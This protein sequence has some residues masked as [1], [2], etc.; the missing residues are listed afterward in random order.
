MNSHS[1]SKAAV[2]VLLAISLLAMGCSAQW[3]SVALADLPVLVQMALNIGTVVTTLQSGQ[4]LSAADAAAIQNISNEASKDLNLLQ[5]LYNDYKTNANAATIQ[6]IQSVIADINTNL[7][8]LLQAAHISDAS[9]SARITA[10]VNLILTTVNSFAS[11]IPATGAVA[12]HAQIASQKVAIPRAK[13]LK[14][15]WNQQICAPTKTGGSALAGCA[16]N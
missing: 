6:K 11:L 8:A 7:P 12:M 5:A 13:D 14:K 3:I 1:R 9:L 10:A 15:Q 2:V 16:V 4:Q